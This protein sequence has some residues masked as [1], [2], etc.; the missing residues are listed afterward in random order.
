MATCIALFG[1]ERGV[2]K[3]VQ[4]EKAASQDGIRARGEQLAFEPQPLVERNR[5]DKGA[6]WKYRDWFIDGLHDAVG[7]NATPSVEDARR[8]KAECAT[9]TEALVRPCW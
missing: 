7:L 3:E 2:R 4:F 6:A 8:S 5:A 1:I 9:R